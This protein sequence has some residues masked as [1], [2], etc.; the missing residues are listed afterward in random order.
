MQP[1]R[2]PERAAEITEPKPAAPPGMRVKLGA[3]IDKYRDGSQPQA[4]F[5]I[6]Y[7]LMVIESSQIQ[8]VK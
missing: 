3:W 1:G 7:W 5:V 4:G 6:G 2:S 8:V